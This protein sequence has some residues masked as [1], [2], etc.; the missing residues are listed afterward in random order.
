[1]HWVLSLKKTQHW[2][3]RK[4]IKWKWKY[5]N[6]SVFATKAHIS[7]EGTTY[8]KK[9]QNQ[10]KKVYMQ[11]FYFICVLICIWY[12]RMHW[13]SYRSSLFIVLISKFIPVFIIILREI[14]TKIYKYCS[15][16]NTYLS[17]KSV[18]SNHFFCVQ[19]KILISNKSLYFIVP[20]F[21]DAFVPW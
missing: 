9:F 14:W 11:K 1:M 7:S 5:L 4:K 18:S 19:H 12:M 15:T 16:W 13:K 21:Q 10:T 8:L 20:A 2:H 17:I 3:W 6:I